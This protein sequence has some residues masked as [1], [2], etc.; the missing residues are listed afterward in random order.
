M[1]FL[2]SLLSLLDSKMTVPAPYSA[3]HLFFILASVAAGFAIADHCK[4][5][6]EAFIRRFLL[7]ESLAVI[8]LEL[9]KQV[10]FSL[11]LA[12]G[13]ITFDYQWYAFPFQFC[14]TPMYIGFFAALVRRKGIH[15]RLC[16][17]LATYSL[18][19]GICVMV[20]PVSVFMDTVGINIQTMVCHGLM[21]TVGIVLLRTGY[22]EVS[23]KTLAGAASVFLVLIL[24]AVGMNELA[25]RTGLLASETFNMFFISPY[26]A[27]EL[28]VYSL[29][30][31]LVPYPVSLLIYAAGF[32]AAAGIILLCCRGLQRLS[33]RIHTGWP[34]EPRLRRIHMP[35]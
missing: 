8:G 4:R 29:I 33:G 12:G 18:F 13:Q 15:R 26:C 7:I 20:Y 32:T 24:C 30:Q 31:K 25:H 14:S 2:H 21:V 11:S 28:P 17:Y 10:N 35:F 23:R 34:M 9:Y 22:V 5:K 3:F 16:A 27:P 1:E 6:D 19:A